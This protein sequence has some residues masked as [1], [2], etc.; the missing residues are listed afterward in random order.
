VAGLELF[1]L[2]KDGSEFPAEILSIARM[3]FAMCWNV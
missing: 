2:R 3:K 1:G